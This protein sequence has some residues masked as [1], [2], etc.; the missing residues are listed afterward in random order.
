MKQS[1]SKALSHRVWRHKIWGEVEGAH[2][3]RQG[4]RG[5]KSNWRSGEQESDE[6]RNIQNYETFSQ[7]SWSLMKLVHSGKEN[8]RRSVNNSLNSKEEREP[9]YSFLRAHTRMGV[10][11]GNVNIC[12]WS[13]MCYFPGAWG[14]TMDNV[15]QKEKKNLCS[16]GDYMISLCVFLNMYM[17]KAHMY[18][19]I[20]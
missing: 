12:I 7:P 10:F 3:A 20:K 15:N 14:K 6:T 11:E 8:S 19:F 17:Q 13:S 2:R 9:S 1:R 18:V 16:C 4:P 5:P